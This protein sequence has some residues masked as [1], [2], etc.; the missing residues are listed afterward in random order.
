MKIKLIPAKAI[1]KRL[2]LL[3]PVIMSAI[4]LAG[5]DNSPTELRMH[6]S[7]WMEFDPQPI[8]AI[9]AERSHLRVTKAPKAQGMSAI[10]SI[11]EK[12]A[13]LAIVENS[14]AF[15]PGVRVVIPAY[16]S[17]L[18]VLV[19]NNYSPQSPN[20]PLKST[21]YYVPE[22]SQAAINFIRIVAERQGL[23]PDQYRISDKFN[24]SE[25]D[26]ILYFG[27]IDTQH[28][29][30]Y[31]P[32]YKLVSL[33]SPL[34][35]MSRFFKEGIGYSVPNTHS[36]VIP[37]FTYDVPGNEDDLL[38]IAVDALLVTHKDVSVRVIYELT[39][40]LL[41][42]KPRFTAAAP[43]LFGGIHESFNPLD[44]SFPMHEGSRRYLNRDEPG[45]LERY[46]ETINLM[47][48]LVFLII[49]GIVAF[50]R[51]RAQRKKDRIDVFYENVLSIRDRQ[52]SENNAELLAE[53]NTLEREAFNSLIVEK[54]AA[55]ESFRIFIDLMERTRNELK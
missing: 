33:Q 13:D 46:A 18:H 2:T 19:R 8:Q 27:P 28:L 24:P 6:L 14:L 3:M 22:S 29:G 4:L 45:I 48:Y 53:L 12:T 52:T 17:V 36:H 37:A 1:L 32:G 43:S 38:T 47:I 55:N 42:Q 51:W 44:L 26:F 41:E 34:N 54:L 40:T 10:Q 23:T 25:T 21:L 50:T 20:Q 11:T 5:C 15:T 49:T 7:S 16:V 35:P 39:R 31:R 9:F 30:W